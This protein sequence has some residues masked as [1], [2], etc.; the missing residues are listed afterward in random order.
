MLDVFDM[1]GDIE[2]LHECP[3]DCNHDDKHQDGVIP[4]EVVFYWTYEFG[5]NNPAQVT[6]GHIQCKLAGRYFFPATLHRDRKDA[7][8]GKDI[9]DLIHN[10]ECADKPVVNPIHFQKREAASQDDQQEEINIHHSFLP[11]S[12]DQYASDQHTSNTSDQAGCSKEIGVC[13]VCPAKRLHG[14]NGQQR[15]DVIIGSLGNKQD[16][17]QQQT[18]AQTDNTKE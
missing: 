15:S 5:A 11:V 17:P 10:H 3:G 7:D 14:K 2:K 16:E 1:V 4:I 13:D 18:I 12:I 9:Q 6:K 8:A